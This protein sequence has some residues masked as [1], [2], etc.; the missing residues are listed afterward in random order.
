MKLTLVSALA[1]SLTATIPAFAADKAKKKPGGTPPTSKMIV[2]PPPT[3]PAIKDGQ[4]PKLISSEMSGQDLL[5]F[6]TVVD[7][8]RL[9]TVL[10]E[11]LKNKADSE[12][13][14]QL[15]SMLALTQEKEN[16]Q[17][18]K[19][20]AT[21]GWTVS[22]EPTSAQKAMGAALEKQQG[23]EF[24]KGVMDKVIAASQQSVGAYETAAQSTDPQIKEFAEKILP[25][26]KERLLLVQRM[27]GAGKSGNQLLR[28]GSTPKPEAVTPSK[29]DSAATPKPGPA[30]NIPPPI[31]P[32][33]STPAATAPAATPSVSTKPI[34]Q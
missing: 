13:I 33:K 11:L 31:I 16:A 19:L 25:L 8:G 3:D 24:D 12:Q 34:P 27:T 14:K 29:P 2:I 1:L 9:Q 6:T 18:T 23:A 15:A 10:V 21:K 7:A 26:A 4:P 30:L 20:A 22:A 17:V 5:F 32:S 28:T